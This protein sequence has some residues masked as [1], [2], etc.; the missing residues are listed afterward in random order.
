[1]SMF[2][3]R[4]SRIDRED[5]LDDLEQWDEFLNNQTLILKQ[6]VLDAQ[7]AYEDHGRHLVEREVFRQKLIES[8]K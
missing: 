2:E 4:Q 5:Q 3:L 6:R 8:L 1:M 7:K